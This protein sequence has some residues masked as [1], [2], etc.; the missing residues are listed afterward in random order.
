VRAMFSS[1]N[2]A[3]LSVNAILPSSV[4]LRHEPMSN[5]GSVRPYRNMGECFLNGL[6]I[7]DP[8]RNVILDACRDTSINC[9][10][11]RRSRSFLQYNHIHI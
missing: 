7:M 6:N 5:R 9:F 3:N 10:R 1:V 2:E 11:V 8:F 4:T